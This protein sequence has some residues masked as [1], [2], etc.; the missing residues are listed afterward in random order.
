[1]GRKS[2]LGGTGEP[3]ALGKG[4]KRRRD[5]SRAE[6]LHRSG[7]SFTHTHPGSR[8]SAKSSR[9]AAGRATGGFVAGT[10]CVV[11]IGEASSL[12]EGRTR[13]PTIMRSPNI[14]AHGTPK[15]EPCPR[16][17]G[18]VGGLPPGRASCGEGG[19]R[20]EVAWV[21]QAGGGLSG[22]SL[23]Q[24]RPPR[25]R[26]RPSLGQAES[27]WRSMTPLQD[28]HGR[29]GSSR[30]SIPGGGLD[31]RSLLS[32]STYDAAAALSWR[33]Q[34]ASSCPTRLRTLWAHP[35]TRARRRSAQCSQ[36]YAASC[37]PYS[38]RLCV[39]RAGNN[40]FR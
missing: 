30:R 13:V 10:A 4:A 28:L 15:L 24:D 22:P 36:E 1:M 34:P 3:V 12:D 29:A 17:T 9:K 38:P 16:S 35:R 8:V 31:S 18:P 14:T 39:A 25:C 20:A 11:G 32:Y 19:R 7:T 2:R 6:R 33:S 26:R 37:G 21:A 40:I 27:R 23:D 5:P